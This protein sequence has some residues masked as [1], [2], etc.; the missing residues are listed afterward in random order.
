MGY[1]RKNLLVK[2]VEIQNIVLEYQKKGGIPQKWVY[3]NIIREKYFISYS[4]FNNYL[5]I[6]AKK[7]LEKLKQK[8]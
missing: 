8:K 5:S 3:E 4:T 2:V 1:N 7:E 6:P